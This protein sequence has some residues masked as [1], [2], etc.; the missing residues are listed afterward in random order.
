MEVRFLGSGDAFGS[1]GRLNTCFM[2]TTPEIRFLIDCGATSLVAMNRCGVDP[3]SI[4]KILLSHLHGDHFGGGVFLLV[5]AHSASK[6]DRPLV[7]AGPRT[8]EKRVMEAMECL[9]PGSSKNPW[10]FDLTFEEYE[11]E[12]E[13]CSGPVSLMAYQA[14]HKAGEGPACALRITIEGKTLTYSGDGAW[15]DGLA[16]AA[17][18]ADLFIAEVNFYDKDVSFHMNLQTLTAHLDEIAPKR[19]ILTHMDEDMLERAK[20]L[21]FETAH[22]GKIVEI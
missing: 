16:K 9:Y 20:N 22:D 21:N 6:R 19:L 12:K 14:N 18:G 2:V 7:V 5:H 1:G 15:S 11:I 13:W 10:R 8:T 4:D 3:N 17:A